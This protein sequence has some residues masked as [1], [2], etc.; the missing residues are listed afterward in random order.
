MSTSRVRCVGSMLLVVVGS[1]CWGQTT[2]TLANG[3]GVQGGTVTLPLVFN[4]GGNSAAGVEW[5]FVYPAASV[6]AV[7]VSAL[8]ALTAASKSLSC[9]GSPGKYTCLAS[10]LNTNLL[11][12]GPIATA[13]FTLSAS[14]SNANVSLT[15]SAA[16][17]LANPVSMAASAGAISVTP[18]VASV[19]CSPS[20]IGPGAVSTC[21][22]TLSPAAPS[23][24][25]VVGLSSNNTNLQVATSVTVAAGSLTNT[26]PATAGTLSADQTATVTAT[27]NSTSASASLSLVAPVTVKSLACS[28][29]SLNS[30]AS[31]ACTV[32]LSKVAPTGGAVVAL[33]TNNWNLTVA[34][35]VTV[36]AGSLTNTF[37]ATAGTL[38]A[39]QTATV[40]ATYNST[41]ASASFSLVAPTTVKSLVCSPTSVSAG[42][43]SACTVT[44][45]K[46]APTG[47]TAVAL[48]SNNSNLHVPAAW[49][50]VAAGS[51][52]SGFSL[53]TNAAVTSSQSALVVATLGGSSQSVAFVLQPGKSLSTKVQPTAIGGPVRPM[54]PRS[55]QPD[56]AGAPAIRAGGIVNSASDAPG[57]PPDGSLA[58]GSFFSIYGTELGPEEP[59]TADRHPLPTTLGG[60]SIRIIQGS[61]QADVRL[62]L[63]SK[64]QINALLPSTVAEGAAQ[65]VVTYNGMTSAPEPITV[66]RTSVGVFYQERDGHS[67]AIAQN[68]HSATD[69]R[70]N[71]PSAPAKPGQTVLL[72][73]TGLGAEERSGI[74]VTITVGGVPAEQ[75]SLSH[76]RDTALDNIWFTIPSGVSFG[77]QVPVAITAGGIAANVTV[78]AITADG[79]PCQ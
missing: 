71:L 22:V 74:P 5:T 33:S 9:A 70:P 29:A 16:S 62:L 56:G 60:V 68:V 35:S 38:L 21:T 79:S 47:G 72:W 59:V 2:L 11:P 36:A 57:G 28:P 63:V 58:Q 13:Q 19:I 44:L 37:P 46:S 4:P 14:A 64:G 49:V 6:S 20:S 7:S 67:F 10:G 66:V 31:G 45:S 26:F 30:G 42:G 24:G 25:A 41:L 53:T 17:V 52:S 43:S 51:A 18:K 3:S 15:S 77:C 78:I 1:V 55:S 61:E 34:A 73:A 69:S 50:T 27:Y 23:G 48:S 39:D 54:E 40:T 65:V 75:V 12:S 8:P 32:T 76:Q